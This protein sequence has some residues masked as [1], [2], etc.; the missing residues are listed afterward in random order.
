[1]GLLTWVFSNRPSIN[2]SCQVDF[3]RPDYLAVNSLLPAT[4]SFKSGI[5][6]LFSSAIL[7]LPLVMANPV[8][9]STCADSV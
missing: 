7:S 9:E 4:V 2:K 8:A 6:G 5:I 1:M 3:G